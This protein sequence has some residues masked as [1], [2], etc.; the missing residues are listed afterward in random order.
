MLEPPA[1][2]LDSFDSVEVKNVL[3]LPKIALNL[4]AFVFTSIKLPSKSTAWL[5][6]APPDT[7]ALLL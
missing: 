1:I 3:L 4:P 2:K 6:F 5:L 7:K